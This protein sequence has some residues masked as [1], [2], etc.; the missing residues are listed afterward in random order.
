MRKS[1]LEP[2]SSI[3]SVCYFSPSSLRQKIGVYVLVKSIK[4][5]ANQKNKYANKVANVLFKG[6]ERSVSK[7]S[8]SKQT[9]TSSL[10]YESP[11]K[12]TPKMSHLH[13]V[14]KEIGV[15]FQDCDKDP[16]RERTVSAAT[17]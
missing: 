6:L 17:T 4:I 2:E 11:S 7:K 14:T 5:E 16:R 9:R 3:F 8:L 1:S 15:S 10:N 13:F 12:N